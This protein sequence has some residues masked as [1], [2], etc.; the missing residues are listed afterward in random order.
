M[1]LRIFLFMGNSTLF[2]VIIELE[3]DLRLSYTAVYTTLYNQALF[4]F[5]NNIPKF[6]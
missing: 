3:L 6:N 5:A 4:L 2:I 1:L